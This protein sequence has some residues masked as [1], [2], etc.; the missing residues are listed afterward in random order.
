M[1]KISFKLDISFCKLMFGVIGLTA[2]VSFVR[3]FSEK[4]NKNYD[5]KLHAIPGNKV[6]E[7]STSNHGKFSAPNIKQKMNLSKIP[8]L[9]INIPVSLTKIRLK[10]KKLFQKDLLLTAS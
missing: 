8:Q 9:L 1:I 5:E 3:H 7:K 4:I 10:R 6:K 2:T